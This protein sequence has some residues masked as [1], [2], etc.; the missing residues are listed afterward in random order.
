[1]VWRAGARHRHATRFPL[2]ARLFLIIGAACAAAF[3]VLEWPWI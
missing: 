2:P 3:L 1:M